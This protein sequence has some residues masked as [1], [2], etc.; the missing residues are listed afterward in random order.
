MLCTLYLFNASIV[1]LVVLPSGRKLPTSNAPA[2]STKK[3]SSTGPQNT[4]SPV[5]AVAIAALIRAS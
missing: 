1:G 3:G 2:R 4:L 5:V